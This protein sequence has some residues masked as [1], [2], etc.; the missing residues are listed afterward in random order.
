MDVKG[1]AH[2]MSPEHFFDFRKADHRADIYS[3]GK[4]LFEA[5]AGKIGEGTLPFKTATLENPETRFFEELD[6][7]IQDATAEKKEER[8]DSVDK[9]HNA[10]RIL[11]QHLFLKNLRAARFST[12]P[13]GS[14]WALQ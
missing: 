4:I 13:D 11:K 12:N 8:T 1:T 7:I 9:L 10:L 2:Y 6:E 14:G 5:V 3:L